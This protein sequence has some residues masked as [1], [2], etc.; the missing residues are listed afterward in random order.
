MTV[1]KD[2]VCSAW[3]VAHDAACHNA[4]GAN[5]VGI[6]AVVRGQ[7]RVIAP[8]HARKAVPAA[9]IAW[10]DCF[11]GIILQEITLRERQSVARPV[12]EGADGKP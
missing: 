2:H 1:G 11:P 6:D 8:R 12:N 10:I 5:S 7:L 4:S 3:M 9:T